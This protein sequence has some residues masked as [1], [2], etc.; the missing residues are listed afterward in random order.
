MTVLTEGDLEF[1]F[2]DAL[3]AFC[4]DDDALHGNHAMKRVDVIAEYEDKWVF[5][6]IKDP[7]NP[8]ATNPD[9][10]KQKLLSGNLIPDLAGKYRDSLWFRALSDG[11]GSKPVY[12]I[13]LLS[14][15]SL[16]P[17]LLLTQQDRLHKA[18]P[19]T[20]SEWCM[21]F[22]AACLIFNLSQ[23][24]SEFGADSVRRISAGA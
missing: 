1:N 23:Y 20:H 9:A 7:D 6:E 5:L 17:A 19:L 13:V 11:L 14:M 3:H 18:L 21:P 2:S 12:Y 22:A 10:F 15:E 4:F 16:D 8:D 24:Q